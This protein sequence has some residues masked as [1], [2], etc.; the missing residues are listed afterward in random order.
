MKHNTAAFTLVEVLTGIVIFAVISTCSWFAVSTLFR[1][2]QLTSNRTIAINLLQ[3]SQEELRR[4]SLTFYDTLETCQFPGPSVAGS[5]GLQTLGSNFANYTRSV[6]TSLL[7]A[8][9][10]IK[11]AI[12]TVT[13]K[14]Q[15]RVLSMSSAVLLA[16]PPDAL[17]GNVIGTVRSSATGNPLI[18][19][20]T[21]LL[22][23][24]T[25]RPSAISKGTLEKSKSG[26]EVNYNFIDTTTKAYNLP[27]GSW[28]LKATHPSYYDYAHPVDIIV[29]SNSELP[30]IDFMMDPKPLDATIRIQLINA[31][32]KLPLTNFFNGT[33]F[34]L[35]DYKEKGK[36][37]AS[38]NSSTGGIY[39]I[40][41]TDTKPQ[42]FTINTNYAY[43]SG[44]VG[45]PSCN[46][47]PYFYH[48]WSSATVQE[49]MTPTCS[50]PYL[51]S[52]SSD[53]ITVNP[54]DNITI[55]VPLFPVPTA[56]IRGKVIDEVTGIG[57]AGAK[58]YA[59][60]P[61]GD[62]WY[63][64]GIYPFATSAA[65]GTYTYTVPA[66]Q[67]INSASLRVQARR[68]MTSIG[69]C[70]NPTTIER[71]SNW[72]LASGLLEGSIVDVD[73]LKIK[74]ADPF[75]CGNVKGDIKNGLSGSAID[76]ANVSVQSVTTTTVLSGEYIYQCPSAGYRLPVGSARFLSWKN[77]YY[78]YDSNGNKWYK[79]ALAVKIKSREIVEYPAKLWPVGRG[80]IIV[81]IVD[82]GTD[83]P[84]RGAQVKLKTYTD[85]VVTNTTNSEG[86]VTFKDT[87]ETWPPV[88]LPIDDPY[89]N[90]KT[91]YLHKISVTPPSDI[92]NTLTDQPT[93]VLK[94]DETLIITV[95]L[96]ASGG[97]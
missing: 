39:T 7:G 20:V 19:G 47:F 87:L 76:N 66:V 35:D 48:G 53:R 45:K 30:Q 29:S 81:K 32:T 75:D 38:A 18:S 3:K 16:R 77:S 57:L 89:Y 5:C 94:K 79:A 11:Q 10:E 74:N 80:T 93:P 64:D 59:Q 63:K 4:A 34:I 22:T 56:T 96:S 51:G 13:W 12:I 17:P 1:G 86:I 54:G 40:K 88:D 28:K 44:Y 73:D 42:S 37:I 68:N 78:D 61:F 97:T 62:S 9:T 60:W 23:K 46:G 6:T 69:C 91:I 70:E 55:N 52:K 58:I 82:E 15:G 14:D 85:T 26:L 43:R 72:V 33:Y 67:M 24:D 36:V 49:D 84:I 27:V 25:L 65:D 95:K 92:Y 8:S 2:E 41:F 83:F 31:E 50:N 71:L 90:G 21:I